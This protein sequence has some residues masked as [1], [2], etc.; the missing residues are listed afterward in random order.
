MGEAAAHE[1]NIRRLLTR[2]ECPLWEI[3]QRHEIEPPRLLVT[4]SDD[5]TCAR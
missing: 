4:L 3:R 2:T 5:C 1:L